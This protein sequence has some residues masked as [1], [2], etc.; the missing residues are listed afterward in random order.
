[1]TTLATSEPNPTA[2]SASPEPLTVPPFAVISGAQVQRPPLFTECF[3]RGP[4]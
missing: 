1:M 3:L 2:S 4:S